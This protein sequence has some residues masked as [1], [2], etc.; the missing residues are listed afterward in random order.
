[1]LPGKALLIVIVPFIAF[2][3][4]CEIVESQLIVYTQ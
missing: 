3:F 2:G 4:C 1:M